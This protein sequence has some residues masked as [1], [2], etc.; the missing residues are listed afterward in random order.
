MALLAAARRDASADAWLDWLKAAPIGDRAH[1]A[2]SRRSK[3]RCGER[4]SRDARGLARLP[5]DAVGRRICATTRWRSLDAFARAPRRSLVEWLDALRRRAR[6]A[7]ARSAACAT[8]P[9]AGRRSPP[10]ASIRRSTRR[11]PRAARGRSRADDARPSSRAGSTTCSS[12]RPIFRPTP[13]DDDVAAAA[14]RRRDHA[15]CAGDAASVR[16]RR[17]ARRRRPPSRRAGRARLA[18]AAQRRRDARACPTPAQRRERELLAFAQVLRLPQRDLARGAGATAPSR[19]ANSAVRRAA[20]ASRSPSAASCAWRAGRIR[21]IAQRRS[22]RRRSGRARRRSRAGRLPQRLSASAFE[23]LRE[24]PYRFFAQSVLRPARGRRAR[25]RGRE[26]RLRQLAARGAARVP[27]RAREA[28]ADGR[29]RHRRDCCAIGAGEPAKRMG[30]TPAAF[31]PFSAS[32]AVFVPRY[33]AWLHEREAGRRV[34]SRGEAELR[35]TPEALGGVELYGRIDRIDVVDG[36]TPARADRLQ[37]RQ[38]QP[39]QGE[40]ARPFEDTQLA[41]Y[42]ALV[43]AGERR[44]RCAPSI[45]RSTRRAGLEADRA[46]STSRRA[47]AALVDGVADDLRRAAR[48]AR[49]C[50][51]SAKERP[52]STATR[53]ACAVATTGRRPPMR[54]CERR[55][56]SD[57]RARLPHRRRAGDAA[58]VLRGCLRSGAQLRRRGLRRLGQDLDAGLAH[59]ARAARRRRAARDPR[60][61]LHAR[62]GRRDAR[63]AGRL[64][65]RLLR[66]R[67]R[68]TPSG[69]RRCVQR[70]VDAGA[71]RGA[72]ARARDA[73][74][75]AC[76][77]PA[78]RSRSAPST[79]G[80]RSCCGSRRWRCSTASAWRPT[81]ELVEDSSRPSPGG[82]ARLPCAPCCA[83]LACAPT[84]RR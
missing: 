42:A 41:F 36:G 31:L 66:R 71:G 54:R 79:P 16:R 34:W 43:G 4:R 45:W 38:R 80:S 9:P 44:C 14:A 76:S 62:R 64:A 33:V 35:A 53:A 60:H 83:T 13:V 48:A 20:V 70:G 55:R 11:A 58:S 19:S 22:R 52:A 32:F 84:T 25:R 21:A 18:A 39:A 8:T 47:R 59:A 81:M 12:A 61:H 1:A 67:A 75:R 50:R 82:D 73:P 10:S 24:C 69:S 7:R 2:R 17:P 57:D 40:R 26:A 29:S 6:R 51:R 68:P 37:D 49:P 72:R 65:R 23:A 15:A 5:L 3:R 27:S 63:A 77:P 46:S 28:G 74:R 56:A 78:G 30:S